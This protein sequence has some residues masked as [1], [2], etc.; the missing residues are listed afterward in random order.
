MEIRKISDRCPRFVDDTEFDHSTS[1]FCRG[2]QRNVQRIITHV[3]VVW[4]SSLLG[5]FSIDDD[6]G[7]ENVVVKCEFALL[8]SLRDYSKHFNVT[9]VWQTIKNETSMNCVQFRGENVNLTLS[10]DVLPKTSSF[11]ISRCCF[12]VDGQ[13]MYKNEKMHEQSVQSYRF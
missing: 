1:L 2:R 7:N 10:A 5:S 12:S 6:N 11:V 3:V 9:K 8:L 13:E 4:L